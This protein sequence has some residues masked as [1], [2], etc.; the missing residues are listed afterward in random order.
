MLFNKEVLFEGKAFIMLSM[1]I[2]GVVCMISGCYDL[3]MA[4]M[5]AW[6]VSMAFMWNDLGEEES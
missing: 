3:G 2:T 1:L 4:F 6:G 5:A